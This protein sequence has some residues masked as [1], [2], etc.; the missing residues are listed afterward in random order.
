MAAPP[1]FLILLGKFPEV[2]GI[3][4]CGVCQRKERG[5]L[6]VKYGWDRPALFGGLQK[7]ENSRSKLEKTQEQ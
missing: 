2:V 4:T 5:G 3:N 1:F 7:L 6:M